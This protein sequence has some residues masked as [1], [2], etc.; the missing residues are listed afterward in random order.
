MQLQRERDKPDRTAELLST[1]ESPWWGVLR[2]PAVAAADPQDWAGFSRAEQ[3]RRGRAEIAVRV[4]SREDRTPVLW[5]IPVQIHRPIPPGAEILAAEVMITRVADER[6][7]SANLTIRARAAIPRTGSA[8]AVDIGWRSMPD[9]SLR[10]AYWRGSKSAVQ[11]VRAPE[12][13]AEV[14]LVHAS[15]HEG[16]VRLPASWRQLDDRL[17][18]LRSGRD[19]DLNRIKATTRAYLKTH[20]DLAEALEL[21]PGDVAMALARSHGQPRQAAGGHRGCGRTT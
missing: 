21:A 10:V 14:L 16:E 1:S 17:A 8:V 12:H 20:P 19:K 2:L 5:D 11:Q 9:G 4:A 13:L 7:V 3:R 18:Q 15:G 6:R